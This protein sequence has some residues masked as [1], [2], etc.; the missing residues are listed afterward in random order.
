MILLASQPVTYVRLGS[1]GCA[2]RAPNDNWN[3]GPLAQHALD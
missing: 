1:F 2:E 3:A